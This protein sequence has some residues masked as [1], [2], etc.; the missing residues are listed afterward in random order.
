MPTQP[1]RPFTGD[2][3]LR[4]VLTDD[5]PIFFDHQRDPEATRMAAFPARTREAFMA[6]WTKI[7]ADDTT[8]NK[9]IVADG[10]VVGNIANFVQEGASY[11]GYWIGR[12]Y[13]GQG[14][15]TRALEAFL[16][17]VPTRPLY[18]FVAAHN[19]ASRRV[20][21]KC[22]FTLSSADSSSA[23]TS[24]DNVDEYLLELRA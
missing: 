16:E 10:Q 9:T 20:L 8:I 1:P 17:Q 2:V 15:A 22:G 3:I 21:E 12:P 11:I 4:D 14:I 5:L 24:G 19:I 7:L 13:W 18:A 6:H 23:D